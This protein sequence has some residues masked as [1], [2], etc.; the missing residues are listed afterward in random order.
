MLI[1]PFKSERPMPENAERRLKLY[2]QLQAYA[3]NRNGEQ[4]SREILWHALNEYFK[5]TFPVM[6]GA[7]FEFVYAVDTR[8]EQICY[9]RGIK[10]YLGYHAAEINLG[11]LVEALHPE[12]RRHMSKLTTRIGDF[13]EQY[14]PEPLTLHFSMTH[15]I[16]RADNSYIKILRQMYPFLMD[17]N[18][19]LLIYFCLCIDITNLV[20]AKEKISFDIIIP[21]QAVYSKSEAMDFFSDLLSGKPVAFTE[22]ELEVVKVWSET[23]SSRVAAERLG[24]TI[25][26]LETHLKN[27]R[28]KLNVRRSLDVVLYAKE[29][30]MI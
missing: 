4:W 20:E 5:A 12:E 27:A 6:S 11:W 7:H 17:K 30:N 25:R 13:V 1:E 9:H 3:D 28:N 19:K 18:H 10:K 15:R 29:H 26:T 2:A 21:R 8:G 14:R 16:R 22:R 23:D 24:I